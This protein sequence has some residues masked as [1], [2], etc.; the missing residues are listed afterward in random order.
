[1]DS[2]ETFPTELLSIIIGDLTTQDSLKSLSS[3]SRRF[4]ILCVPFLFH[5]LR[6]DFSIAGFKRLE[7]ISVSDIAQ[8][9]KVIQ[10]YAPE[11]IDPSEYVRDQKD[12]IWSF[13]GKQVPYKDIYT[14]F[15]HLVHE[16]REILQSFPR[17]RGLQSI[18]VEFADGIKSPFRWFASRLF[19][20]WEESFL[21]H[22]EALL[23]AILATKREG[24]RITS[25]KI[26]GFYSHLPMT[27]FYLAE[28]LTAAVEDIANAMTT[29]PFPALRQLVLGHCWLGESELGG[30]VTNKADTLQCLELNNVSVSAEKVHPSGISLY[31][32][33][34]QAVAESMLRIRSQGILR[35]IIING[36]VW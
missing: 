18:E 21:L 33:D 17:F 5:R 32:C 7:Q 15:S 25:L 6:V 11:L 28:K 27:D 20:D 30:F 34:I 4:R 23:D 35:R 14:Y 22:F 31:R 26:S 10:Y 3:V 16:Q 9:V 1:M 24:T 19:V 2:L 12:L 8:Y 13:R 36:I 29:V